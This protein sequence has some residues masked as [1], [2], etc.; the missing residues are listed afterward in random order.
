MAL[1][2]RYDLPSFWMSDFFDDDWVQS[3]NSNPAV[4][5][6]ELDNEYQVELA[7][8]GLKREDFH[9]DVE[10]K[11]L[12]ISSEKQEEKSDKENGY[13]RREFTYNAFHRSFTLPE[14]TSEENIKASY[15]DGI[16][17]LTIPKTKAKEQKMKK[18]IEV[19]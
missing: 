16:L 5:V 14:N 2:K 13:T 7:A 15:Q 8:P 10:N 6:K 11:V 3:R 12:S 1:I 9:I 19:K 17:K 4:N 18:A